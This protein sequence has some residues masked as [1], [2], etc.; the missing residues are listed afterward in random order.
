[1][2]TVSDNYSTNVLIDYFTMEKLNEFFAE[3]GYT[4]TKIERRM[5]DYD[6][7][8]QGKDNYTSINDVMRFLDKLYKNKDIFPYADM[9]DI[10][11]NQQRRN[12]IPA[13]LPETTIIANKTGELSDVENDIGIVFSEKGDFAVAFLLTSLTDTYSARIAISDCTKYL[14]NLIE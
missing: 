11:I 5:L 10:M 9:I 6:A 13:Y 1:M 3:N 12:K 8:A 14:Y 2:I 7:M 4:D